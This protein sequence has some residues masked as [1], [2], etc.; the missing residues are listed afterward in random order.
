[1][2]AAR[3]AS[4]RLALEGKVIIEQKKAPVDARAWDAEGR[5]GI[6][7]LRAAA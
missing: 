2:D 5:K 4:V 6:I 7:R 1:M 3:R